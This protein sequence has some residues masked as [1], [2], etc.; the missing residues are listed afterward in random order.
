[1]GLI[2]LE[3]IAVGESGG[4]AALLTLNR[5]DQLNA[6]DWPVIQRLEELL[7]AMDADTD[8]RVVLLTGRG[9]AFSAGGDLKSYIK[10]QQDP[11]AFTGFLDDLHRTFSGIRS[12]RKPVVALVNGV[13]AAGGLELLLSCDFAFAADSATIGDLHLTY[14]QMGGGGVLT[15]LPRMIGPALARELIFSGRMLSAAEAREWGIVNRVVNDPDLLEAGL[16]FARA[17]AD[18]SPLAVANAKFVL[19]TAWAQGTGVD[20][21]LRLE[22]ERNAFYCLTSDDARE[23][24]Q[25][26]SQK[27]KPSY[28]GR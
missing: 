1:M 2:D 14:G 5:P 25:A 15:L 27:R 11:V 18:R 10:L 26:F 21:G 9:R 12:M 3:R 13:T 7:H 4:C 17:I 19:N 8:I 28:T 24:L 20:E 16:E 22:R 6:L 23:G